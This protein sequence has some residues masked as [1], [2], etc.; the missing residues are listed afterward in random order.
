MNRLLEKI[1]SKNLPQYVPIKVENY[2]TINNCFYNLIDKVSID[3]GKIIYG[4][5]IHQT[6]LLLEAERHAVW[7]SPSG[8]LVDITPDEEYS[9]KTL[10]LE[11]DNGW[12]YEGQYSDNIR[13]NITDNPL[14]DDFILLCESITKLWQTGKR[15][16]K[17][18]IEILEPVVNL[19]HL[20]EK[21]KIDRELFILSNSN[22]ESNCYCGSL[23]KY[24][25]CHGQD[26]KRLY[27]EM[28]SKVEEMIKKNTCR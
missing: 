24:K 5:K 8:E 6:K 21:D 15:K 16:S 13:I 7:K 19:I 20:L 23:L 25:D 3:K 2:S 22:R 14:V 1:G 4:W 28:I 9:D 26:L 11:E 10:F 18:E 12:T 27:A 17:L